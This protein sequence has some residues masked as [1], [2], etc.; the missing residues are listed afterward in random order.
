MIRLITSTQTFVA[1]CLLLLI[2][3]LLPASWAGQVSHLPHS[4]VQFAIAPISGQLHHLSL[5]IRPSEPAA[6]VD[7]SQRDWQRQFFTQKQYTT[8]LAEEVRILQRQLAAFKRI[9]AVVGDNQQLSFVASNVSASFRNGGKVSLMIDHGMS[10]GVQLDDAVV[11]GEYLIGK[12]D[13]VNAVTSDVRL[14]TSA[15]TYLKVRIMPADPGTGLDTDAKW[16]RLDEDGK[17]FSVQVPATTEI[18]PGD[19]AHLADESWPIEANGFVVGQVT[20]VIADPADPMLYRFVRIEPRV[21]LE[22]LDEVYVLADA[23]K[24]GETLP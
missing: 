12:I 19:I 5:A 7:T 20:E 23:A 14:I 16:I 22:T 15:D 24:V 6:L 3:A 18:R 4:F 10:S 17:A 21:N 2:S 1:I 13:Q 9:A 11:V 8:R